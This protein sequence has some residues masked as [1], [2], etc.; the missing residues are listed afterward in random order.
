[1][2]PPHA[3]QLISGGIAGLSLL[4]LATWVWLLWRA[5]PPGRNALVA[6]LAVLLVVWAGVWLGLA[7]AGLLSN[8]EQRPPL[9]IA[10][11]PLLILGTVTL[12][13]SLL[14]TIIAEETPLWLLVG[15]Q[16]FRLPLELVMHAAAGEGV[17]P[18]QMTFGPGGL[19]YD[20][21]TGASALVLAAL[22]RGRA[23]P[24]SVL[25]GWNIMGSLLLLNIVVVAVLSTP[26][27]AR[28]GSEPDHLNTWVLFAPYVWLP[29]VLVGSAFFGHLLIFKK[30]GRNAHP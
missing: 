21:V 26:L 27:F 9:F 29:A 15:I 4:M 8:L 24:K 22:L 30:L 6:R 23:L 19:N 16:T 18:V 10:L 11:V 20:I 25:M 2:Q 12:S 7:E 13:R 3:S 1:M 28:F 14:G 5:S 17:M